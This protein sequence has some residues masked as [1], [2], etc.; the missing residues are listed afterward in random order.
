MWHSRR[1]SSFIVA[2]LAFFT[3]HV[4]GPLGAQTS[5]TNPYR[6]TFGWEN[7]PEGTRLGIEGDDGETYWINSE[8]VEILDTEQDEGP[9]APPSLKRGDRVVWGAGHRRFSPDGRGR[10][11]L[12]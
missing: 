7:L 3:V 9:P 5:T 11:C 12:R 6:A 1:L 4:G 2:S 10:L 8:N